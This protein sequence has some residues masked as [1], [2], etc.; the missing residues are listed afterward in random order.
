MDAGLSVEHGESSLPMLP[1]MVDVLPDGCAL[2]KVWGR[3]RLW[4]YSP[5]DFTSSEVLIISDRARAGNSA[6][7]V[8]IHSQHCKHRCRSSFSLDQGPL[9]LVRLA[10][11]GTRAASF[12]HW[13]W[14]AAT[15]ACATS[16][17]PRTLA[18]WWVDVAELGAGC[19][20]FVGL[21]WM[22]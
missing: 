9:G 21:R 13:I 4:G 15:F 1:T 8:I 5:T 22:D 20:F 19:S 11:A 10:N 7:Q 18:K 3:G 12:T 16:S 14:V 17:C 6:A 2:S